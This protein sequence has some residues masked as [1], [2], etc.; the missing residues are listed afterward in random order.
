MPPLLCIICHLG[1]SQNHKEMILLLRKNVA[2]TILVV[3][4]AV[5]F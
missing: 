2:N 3:L 1:Y 4:L 5:T